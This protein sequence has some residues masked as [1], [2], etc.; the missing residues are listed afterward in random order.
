M[1]EPSVIDYQKQGRVAL[2]T[3]NNPPANT[4]TVDSLNRLAALVDELNGDGDIRSLVLTGEG[5]K[6]FC[7]GAELSLFAD[8]DKGKAHAMAQAFGR[9]FEALSEFRGLSVAAINGYAMGGGLEAALACDLR[10]AAERAVM[11]LPE[12][13]VGLLPCA[14][15]T[16]LLPHLVGEAWAKRLILC[17][18]RLKAEQALHI[19][20]VEEVMPK[21]ELLARAMALADSAGRQSPGSVAVCKTL[22]QSARQRPLNEGR[23]R[24]RDAFMALFDTEDQREG[25]NAFLEKREPTWRNR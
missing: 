20:L 2:L 1:G 4:W 11:G 13:R 16:Q 23:V 21:S 18:E 17:G 3:M 15:G 7:A 24:E 5:E 19:G 10:I 9:A 25:V 6:F 12:A 8:G 14:G 22:I